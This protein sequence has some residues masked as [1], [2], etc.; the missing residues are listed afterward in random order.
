MK[1][2]EAVVEQPIKF[3]PLIRVSTEAQ[4][5]RGTSLETQ[6]RYLKQTIDRLGGQVVD[7]YGG[8][9]H[10]TAN[11]ERAELDR[12]MTDALDGRVDAV[13][14][15][16]ISRWSR[17]N[18][19]NKGNL[20]ALRMKGVRFFVGPMEYELTNPEPFFV[21]GMSVE[22]GEL[23]AGQQAYKSVLGKIESA[24]Q[25]RPSCG[26]RPYGRTWSQ[27]DGWQV[28]PEAKAKIEAIARE[29]LE[30]N[31]GFNELGRKFGMNG[32]YLWRVLTKTAGA[33]WD[34]RF[35]LEWARIDETVPT[36]VPPLL[37][38]ETIQAIK[39]R[40]KA[41]KTYARGHIKHRYLLGRKIFDTDT[42]KALTGTAN[43]GGL[44]YYRPHSGDGYKYSINAEVLE[45]AVLDE[46]AVM[47]SN[48]G[49][50][51]AAVFE[52]HESSEKVVKELLDKRAFHFKEVRQVQTEMDRIVAAIGKGIVT[53]DQAQ[54]NLK[55]LESRLANHKKE[56]TA[57]DEQLLALPRESEIEAK[58]NSQDAQL[59]RR[60]VESYISSG[61]AFNDMPDDEL[62]DLVNLVFGGTGPGG[63]RF[64]VYIKFLGGNPHRYEFEAYGRLGTIWGHLQARSGDVYAAAERP[65]DGD[66]KAAAKAGK[67]VGKGVGVEVKTPYASS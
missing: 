17:D 20:K 23:F 46:L 32:Q 18:E 7:W 48:Q 5:D 27:E 51:R 57:I 54:R 24:R 15:A 19:K 45:R 44:R 28:D 21:L 41:R 43:R 25:G 36:P 12:L 56:L 62:Q 9:E 37:P 67:I 38:E 4:A 35:R 39:D 30:T 66:T 22:A 50:F 14:V 47:L 2:G 64:G 42:G 6:R 34:Q 65:L 31:A 55:K 53:D 49:D 33:T 8:Q 61:V 58:R 40:A 16:D 59:V 13:I 29:Y 26:K 3:A 10:A 1:K 63:R 11:W 52:G 60:I